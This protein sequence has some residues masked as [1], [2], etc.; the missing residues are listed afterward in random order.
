MARACLVLFVLLS[1]SGCSEDQAPDDERVG[2]ATH[3]GG[4][5]GYAAVIGTLVLDRPCVRV[6]TDGGH[7]TLAFPVGSA[8]IEGDHLVWNGQ[9]YADG[10]DIDLVGGAEREDVGVDAPEGCAGPYFLVNP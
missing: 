1:M 7:T 10:D 9:E 6:R 2:L 3:D 5:Q 8:E 4:P